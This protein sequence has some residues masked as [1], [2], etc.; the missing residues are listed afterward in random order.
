MSP[1]R[2]SSIHFNRTL[3]G[4]LICC[5]LSADHVTGI[6]DDSNTAKFPV[7]RQTGCGSNEGSSHLRSLRSVFGMD[8][9][10]QVVYPL[11]SRSAAMIS[12]RGFRPGKRY[13]TEIISFM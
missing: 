7:Y 12:G 5:Y 3:L 6:I 9:V 8:S 2:S 1:S 13:D 10:G 11:T 4:T